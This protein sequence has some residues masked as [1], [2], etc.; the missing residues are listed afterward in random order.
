MSAITPTLPE[1]PKDRSWVGHTALRGLASERRQIERRSTRRVLTK[2]D[3]YSLRNIEQT[4]LEILALGRAKIWGDEHGTMHPLNLVRKQMNE[5]AADNLGY[6][7][8]TLDDLAEIRKQWPDW[9]VGEDIDPSEVSAS[10]RMPERDGLAV[11]M[12]GCGS[13][14]AVDASPESPDP[15]V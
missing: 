6:R 3:V 13:T 1:L 9:N 10:Q 4:R 15:P 11:N 5:L 8:L 12:D 14:P 2:D 7:C